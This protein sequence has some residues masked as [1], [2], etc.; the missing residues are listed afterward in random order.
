M[1]EG[2][3]LS[4]DQE[5]TSFTVD[6]DY[7]LPHVTDCINVLVCKWRCK[8][9]N[10]NCNYFF[11]RA[12]PHI[13][14]RGDVRIVRPFLTTWNSLGSIIMSCCGPQLLLNIFT[15]VSCS[16]LLIQTVRKYQ[17]RKQKVGKLSTTERQ[18]RTSDSLSAPKLLEASA[19]HLFFVIFFCK[20]HV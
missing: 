15:N 1:C 10:C 9:H 13:Y 17:A 7:C 19:L 18:K 5:G 11:S 3:L 4:F 8:W 14:R 12:I 2:D 6:D 16:V 20:W